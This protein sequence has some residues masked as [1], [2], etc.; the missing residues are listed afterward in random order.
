VLAMSSN[1]LLTLVSGFKWHP[2]ARH[3][4][5][6]IVNPRFLGGMSSWCS[7]CHQA[8]YEPSFLELKDIL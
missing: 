2:S 7:P 8:H 5:K 1:A 6:R 3:V 4:I